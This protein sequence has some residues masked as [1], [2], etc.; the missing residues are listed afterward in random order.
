MSEENSIAGKRDKGG[1]KG[2]WSGREAYRWGRAGMHWE[3][4]RETREAAAAQRAQC[5]DGGAFA[6]ASSTHSRHSI[7]R[8]PRRQMGLDQLAF[9]A[10][11]PRPPFP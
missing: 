3:I 2:S 10:S 11:A 5:G 8:C 4:E 6:G 1:M 9:H 7:L